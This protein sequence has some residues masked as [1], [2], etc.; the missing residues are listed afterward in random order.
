MITQQTQIKL[1]VYDVKDRAQ[2]TVNS[3]QKVVDSPP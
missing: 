3:T 2:G 1:S